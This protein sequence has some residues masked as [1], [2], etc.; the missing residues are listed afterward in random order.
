[1]PRREC[2]AEYAAQSMPRQVHRAEYVASNT[3]HS[4]ECAALAAVQKAVCVANSV[5]RHKLDLV[6]H[7]IQTGSN[8]TW[9]DKLLW[10]QTWCELDATRLAD[11]LSRH[12]VK[13]VTPGM[14]R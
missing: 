3:Q 13:D 2:R 11:L 14:P 4:I 5:S 10:T 7:P 12:Q 8:K 6:R 9:L 1:M